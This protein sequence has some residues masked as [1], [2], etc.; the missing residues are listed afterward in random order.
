M[1]LTADRLLGHMVEKH[2]SP[3]WTCVYCLYAMRSSEPPVDQA[4]YDFRSADEC[5]SHMEEA[6][7]DIVPVAQRSFAVEL[8]KRQMIGPLSCPLCEF[9]VA[10]MTSS[11]DDHILKHMR[12]FSLRALPSDAGE[13]FEKGSTTLQV[14]G[15]AGALSYTQEDWMSEIVLAYPN[16]NQADRINVARELLP[17][18]D[19]PFNKYLPLYEQLDQTILSS[20]NCTPPLAELW[21]SLFWILSGARETC[22]EYNEDKEYPLDEGKVQKTSFT[23]EM[24]EEMLLRNFDRLLGAT[25]DSLPDLDAQIRGKCMPW[26][27]HRVP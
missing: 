18:I 7:C 8:S 22:R 11:V 20:R 2:S 10:N 15:S 23:E 24:I 19:E 12:E 17:F 26:N 25:A 21:G 1:Y 14:P 6:H 3:I 9:A 4:P 16:L 13:L 5:E 27:Q